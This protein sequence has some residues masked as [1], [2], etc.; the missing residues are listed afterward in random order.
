VF[1]R[2][3]AYEPKLYST[4]EERVQVRLD[5]HIILDWSSSIADVAK[6]Q[7]RSFHSL[8]TKACYKLDDF[9]AE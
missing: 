8:A 2:S 1:V 4:K 7:M 5:A 3:I 6:R 9:S